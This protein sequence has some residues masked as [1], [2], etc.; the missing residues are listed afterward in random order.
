MVDTCASDVI[1]RLNVE[2]EMD[3]FRALAQFSDTALVASQ[4]LYL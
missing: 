2:T 1:P 3:H 4:E